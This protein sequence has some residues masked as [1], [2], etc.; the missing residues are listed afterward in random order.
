MKNKII[1]ILFIVYIFTFAILGIILKDEYIST[2]ERRKLSSFPEYALS[3]EYVTKLDKYLLNKFRS[4]H[5]KIK[6]RWAKSPRVSWYALGRKGH[7]FPLP[8]CQKCEAEN[9]LLPLVLP[10]VKRP[11][12]LPFFCRNP[13]TKRPPSK[14]V[15]TALSAAPLLLRH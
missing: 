5:S 9:R 12:T 2:T 10:R 14:N 6:S 13:T 3:S 4:E 7:T 11:R 8:K 15:K 1:T